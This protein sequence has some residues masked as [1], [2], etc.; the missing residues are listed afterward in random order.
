M[1][2]PPYPEGGRAREGRAPTDCDWVDREGMDEW[3]NE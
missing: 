1:H 2:C 3:M